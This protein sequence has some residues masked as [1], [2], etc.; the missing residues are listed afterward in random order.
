[1]IRR[2]IKQDTKIE[3]RTDTLGVRLYAQHNNVWYNT[4]LH[5]HSHPGLI[6]KNNGDIRIGTT[7][8]K[9]TTD[10]P[11]MYLKNN[12]DVNIDGKVAIGTDVPA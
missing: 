6:I 5:E 10:H 9:T 8:G 1:M 4:P 2:E 11:I 7:K 12:G 3:L